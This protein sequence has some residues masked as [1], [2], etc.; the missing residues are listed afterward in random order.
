[1]EE[2]S[3]AGSWERTHPACRVLDTLGT[4]EACA[5]GDGTSAFSASL[6]LDSFW[7]RLS[8]SVVKGGCRGG[9]DESAD[10]IVAGFALCWS[11]HDV[12]RGS[13][14]PQVTRGRAGRK[15]CR[16]RGRETRGADT[17]RFW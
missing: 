2:F 8:C 14:D 6:R 3:S 15:T 7:S 11:I 16:G 12:S 10:C 13:S 5:P 17:R 9:N 1:M 4:L